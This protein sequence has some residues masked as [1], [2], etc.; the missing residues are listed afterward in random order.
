M[1]TFLHHPG[2]DWWF[3]AV[4]RTDIHRAAEQL[5]QALLQSH[6]PKQPHRTV[7]LYQQV[8]ITVG[9]RFAAGN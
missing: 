9:P 5:F 8:N 4:W 6:Q 1:D 3:Q 2:A 7:E